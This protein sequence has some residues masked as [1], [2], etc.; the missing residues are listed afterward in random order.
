M[1]TSSLLVFSVHYVPLTSIFSTRVISGAK[2]TPDLN[3]LLE[4]KQ[5]GCTYLFTI[6]ST[7]AKLELTFLSVICPETAV[8]APLETLNTNLNYKI[9]DD[10]IGNVTDAVSKSIGKNNN[11]AVVTSPISI[12]QGSLSTL[13]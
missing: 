1:S 2:S 10:F 3:K 13:Q 6:S 9:L 12:R 5:A 4:R 8:L 11:A 7:V